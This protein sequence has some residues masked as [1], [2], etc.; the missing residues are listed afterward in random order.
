MPF[1]PQTR[2]MLYPRTLKGKDAAKAYQDVLLNLMWLAAI[3]LDNIR[4]NGEYTPD[5]KIEI[6]LLE[7]KLIKLIVGNKPNFY[8][9]KLFEYSMSLSKA[10]L[11]RNDK[12]SALNELEKAL[13]YAE[14][15][16]MRPKINKYEPC[17][18][19]EVEDRQEYTSKH[20][21]KTNYDELMDFISE[22]NYFK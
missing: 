16:E 13:G 10:Y 12:E 6:M 21:T 18:L 19:S 17:W 22:A 3:S 11:M 8:N 9:D 7:E 4:W 5:E 1:I 15:Y 2:D 14:A 20:S